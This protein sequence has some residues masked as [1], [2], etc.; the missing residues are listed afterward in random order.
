M[1][2]KVQQT[3][4]HLF[5]CLWQKRFEAYIAVIFRISCKTLFLAH[6]FLRRVLGTSCLFSVPKSQ[7]VLYG[8][9]HTPYIHLS[10]VSIL[11]YQH[12]THSIN[13]ILNLSR[14]SSLTGSTVVLISF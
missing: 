4:S 11:G 3:L 12:R 1:M 8:S 7:V 10:V 13:L 9:H 5:F 2:L 6:I 14:T